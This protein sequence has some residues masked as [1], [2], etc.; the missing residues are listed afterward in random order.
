MSAGRGVRSY[1]CLTKPGDTIH[2]SSQL[3]CMKIPILAEDQEFSGMG[4]VA[5]ATPPGVCM[6]GT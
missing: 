4:R 5:V 3:V 2:T 6:Y 1:A